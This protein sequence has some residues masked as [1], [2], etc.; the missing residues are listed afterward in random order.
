MLF[1]SIARIANN[2][3]ITLWL[4]GSNTH[5]HTF[6]DLCG[7]INL[8]RCFAE[9]HLPCFWI[10]LMWF[11]LTDLEKFY[12][13]WVYAAMFIC[14]AFIYRQAQMK[15]RNKCLPSRLTCKAFISSDVSVYCKQDGLFLSPSGDLGI[16]L[17]WDNHP[18]P[19]HH[20]ISIWLLK[21][22]SS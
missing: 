14:D 13:F 1:L 10:D 8:I 11:L 7:M 2:V 9:K 18:I 17:V 19:P 12:I 15:R 4:S 20:H 6:G 16:A 5:G 21:S 22:S 3:Q